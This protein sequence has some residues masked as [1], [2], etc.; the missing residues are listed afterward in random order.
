[1]IKRKE[2][3]LLIVISGPSGCGKST[4]VQMLL[5]KR[6]NI[7]LSISDTTR[8]PRGEEKDGVDYNFITPKEFKDNIKK[9]KYLEY[10]MVYT[11]KYYGTQSDFVDKHL[12]KGT[13]VILEIDIEGA[14]K[15]NEKRKDAVFIFVMPPSMK[16]LKER[17]VNRQ[18]E[19]KEQV[20]ER[21]KKAYKEIN[22]V[23]KYNYVVVNDNLDDA[24][25]KMNSIITC[26]KCRVDRIE[27]L[28]V[29]NQEEII[30]EILM[31]FDKKRDE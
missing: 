26:E 5:E 24:L 25:D 3:G 30:H 27:E 9:D 1:M 10:A 7:I 21:F 18:T 2:N 22:E 17:L 28:D 12:N 23:S 11:D 31:D 6:D 13:D 8:S 4:L 15:V 16:V 29:G 19:T 14:R 20:I